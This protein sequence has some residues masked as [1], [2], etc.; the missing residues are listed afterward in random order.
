MLE[1]LNFF[2]VCILLVI[3]IAELCVTEEEAIKRDLFKIFILR[4]FLV[5]LTMA[6]FRHKTYRME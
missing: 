6:L 3:S 5:N 1:T 2:H 4:L